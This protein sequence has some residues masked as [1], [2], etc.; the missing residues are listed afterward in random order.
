MLHL[1]SVKSL[2]NFTG[3]LVDSILLDFRF[4]D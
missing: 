4:Y 3:I 1:D 2:S